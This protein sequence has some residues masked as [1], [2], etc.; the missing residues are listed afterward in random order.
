MRVG[1]IFSF[2]SFKFAGTNPRSTTGI[3]HSQCCMLA[4]TDYLQNQNK[5]F[6]RLAYNVWQ[7]YVSL[8]VRPQ[9]VA[10][11]KGI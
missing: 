1:K 7:I 6:W 2:F 8:K 9:N 3:T 10:M 5:G 11:K 4:A